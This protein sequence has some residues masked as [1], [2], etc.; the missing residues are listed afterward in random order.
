MDGR[1]LVPLIAAIAIA[2]V[3]T[4]LHRRLPPKLAARFVIASMILVA[5][6]AAPTAALVGLAFLAHAPVVGSGF[7]WCAHAIGMHDSVPSWLGLLAL[8]ML[9][10]GGGRAGRVMRQHRTLRLDAPLPVHIAHSHTP[11]A[12]TLPGR[13]GQIV[14]STALVDILDDTEREVV[15]A[16]EQAHARFRHDRYLLA[17]ELVAAAIPPLRAMA[18]RAQ[19]SVE[20]WAD[21]AAAT[22]CGDRRLVALTL[23]K[24]ALHSTPRTVAAFSGLGVAA[25]IGALLEPPVA[26]PNRALSAAL[27]SSVGATAVLCAAQ[28]HGIGRLVAILCPH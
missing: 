28:L 26:G 4:S 9:L 16:H 23:G 2:A 1:Q 25:R 14:M 18:R 5:I 13:G 15:L 10:V 7:R 17:A 12:V 11:Y 22:A 19:Y 20:R 6:A 8:A 21:E 27:W 24:V 3:V